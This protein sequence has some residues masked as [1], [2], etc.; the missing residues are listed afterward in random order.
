MPEPKESKSN[1]HFQISVVKSVLRI[2][3]CCAAF[4]LLTSNPTAAFQSFL[5]LFFAAE[6]LGVVE[7][8]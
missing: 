3:G 2:F 8:M 7:E 5:F 1:R 6:C 4:L